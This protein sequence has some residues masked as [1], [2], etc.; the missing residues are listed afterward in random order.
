MGVV[1]AWSGWPKE[2]CYTMYDS[3]Q[4]II[5]KMCGRT[6]LYLAWFRSYSVLTKCSFF[7][8]FSPLFQKCK[9]G[10]S[11]SILECPGRSPF[12][13]FLDGFMSWKCVNED[14]G[15]LPGPRLTWY[16]LVAATGNPSEMFTCHSIH[17]VKVTHAKPKLTQ[18][19]GTVSHDV[20][21]NLTLAL[22]E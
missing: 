19:H 17:I 15:P 1:R 22:Y 12:F 10:P 5:F 8:I 18:H 4:T 21:T 11:V 7:T 3:L 13:S 9:K 2:R 6:F 20:K 14:P 16:R